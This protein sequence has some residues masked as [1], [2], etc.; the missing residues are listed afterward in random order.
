M[1]WWLALLL[2]LGGGLGAGMGGHGGSGGGG[3][4]APKSAYSYT[5]NSSSSSSTSSDTTVVTHNTDYGDAP[6]PYGIAYHSDQAMDWLGDSYT[7]ESSYPFSGWVDADDGVSWS[8]TQF[9]PGQEAT[10]TFVATGYNPELNLLSAAQAPASWNQYVRLWV[11]WDQNGVWDD[12]EVLV[13]GTDDYWHR[14]I[15]ELAPGEMTQAMIDW[16]FMVPEDALA[17][18]TWLRVRL[19]RG[20]MGPA[21]GVGYGEVEDYLISVGA[22]DPVVPEPS[23]LLLFGSA[24]LG[25]TGFFR[26]HRVK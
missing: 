20:I 7:E 12:D 10:I 21:S 8:I 16:T 6:E 2:A 9:M 25:M 23:T 17:G 22:S 1:N 18:D 19:G 26:K 15:S 14:Y 5:S 11:D 3:Y 13:M 24:L 4:V